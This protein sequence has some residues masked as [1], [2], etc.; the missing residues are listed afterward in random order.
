MFAMP[1]GCF[2]VL[3]RTERSTPDECI[4]A[5]RV[6]VD[7]VAERLFRL[8]GTALVT[9][10]FDGVGPL[11]RYLLVKLGAHVDQGFLL[12]DDLPNGK[13]FGTAVRAADTFFALCGPN[14]G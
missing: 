6:K 8:H 3:K 14:S 2:Q 10:Q 13:S 7:T 5:L 12:A 4:E 1:S 11:V 9:D